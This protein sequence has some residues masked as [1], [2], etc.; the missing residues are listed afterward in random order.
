[1]IVDTSALVAI[2]KREVGYESLR[3]AIGLEGGSLP[4]PAQVEYTMVAGGAAKASEAKVLLGAFH[5]QGLVTQAFTAEHAAIAA[6]A[7]VRFGKGNGG[8]GVLNLL[9]LMVYAVARER[10]EPLLCTGKDFATTDIEIHA[11]SRPY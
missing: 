9:D 7:N 4:A 8:G 10:G 11:A 3:D 5:E 1:M 6:E 2:L